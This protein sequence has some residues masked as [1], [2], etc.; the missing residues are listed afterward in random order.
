MS[1]Y[2][3][4]MMGMSCMLFWVQ[5]KKITCMLTSREKNHVMK[6]VKKSWVGWLT[7]WLTDWLTGW[8]AVWLTDWLT[9]WLA[10]WLAGWLTDWLTDWLAG[11]LTDWLTDWLA[12]WLTYSVSCTWFWIFRISYVLNEQGTGQKYSILIELNK[13]KFTFTLLPGFF[14]E[15]L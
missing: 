5:E 14:F 1:S 9:G 3:V 11:W 15:F 6:S 4:V 7:D 8:L 12:G 2:H 13:R 10:G